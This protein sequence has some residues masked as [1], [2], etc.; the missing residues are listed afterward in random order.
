MDLSKVIN[1]DPDYYLAYKNRGL[2]YLELSRFNKAIKDFEKV[3]EIAPFYNKVHSVLAEAYSETQNY[4]KAILNY[5]KAISVDLT[6]E[7]NYL[8]FIKPSQRYRR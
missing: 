6:Q 7:G 8:F 5:E 3:L 2:A 1:I 4:E